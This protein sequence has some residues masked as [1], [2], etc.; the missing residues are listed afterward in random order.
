MSPFLFFVSFTLPIMEGVIDMFDK[1]RFSYHLSVCERLIRNNKFID[2]DTYEVTKRFKKH[3][4][5]LT[6]ILNAIDK[7][8][9]RP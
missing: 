8:K 6:D 7:K 9:M 1:L 4:T 2:H 5:K 3:R